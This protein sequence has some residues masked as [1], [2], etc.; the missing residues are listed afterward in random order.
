MTKRRDDKP[1]SVE[2][3]GTLAT[4]TVGAQD[5][6]DAP[7]PHYEGIG[8]GAPGGGRPGE[9]QRTGDAPPKRPR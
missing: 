6:D 8:G 2:K 3:Q 9:G 4:T 1:E 7:S 5:A